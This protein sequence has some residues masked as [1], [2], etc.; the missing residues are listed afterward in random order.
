M[1]PT[2]ARIFVSSTWLD[3]QP[4]RHAVEDAI[5]RMNSGKF[6][7]ERLATASLSAEGAG[8]QP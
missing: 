2:V 6:V 5:N 3:L 4:E 8:A 1:L 7:G